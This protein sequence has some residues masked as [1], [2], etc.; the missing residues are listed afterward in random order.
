MSFMRQQ[1]E[2]KEGDAIIVATHLLPGQHATQEWAISA[3]KDK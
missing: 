2:W 3:N 1:P